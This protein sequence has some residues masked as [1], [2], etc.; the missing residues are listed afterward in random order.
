M[1]LSAPAPAQMLSWLS[2]KDFG[3]KGD[4]QEVADGAMTSGSP[5]L[6]S[7]TANFTASDV[8]KSASV[9][10]AGASNTFLVAPIIG[11][12]SPTTVTL[13][14]N[15]SATVNTRTILW[16]TD[17]TTALQAWI[18]AA[19]SGAK[20]AYLPAGI[21][22]VT[23][24]L[25]APAMNGFTLCGDGQNSVL[26]IRDGSFT[27]S[28]TNNGALTVPGN[29]SN[30]Y[31][32]DFR[33]YGGNKNRDEQ[34]AGVGSNGYAGISLSA[35]AGTLSNVEVFGISASGFSALSFA[36]FLFNGSSYLNIF[37]CRSMQN[38][39][40]FKFVGT[41]TLL[42]FYGCY[43]SSNGAF[44]PAA[45]NTTFFQ[46]INTHITFDTCLFDEAIVGA[47]NPPQH[48]YYSTYACDWIVYRNCT[49]F[50]YSSCT[51][52]TLEGSAVQNVRLE[53]CDVVPYGP[54]TNCSG[55][56]IASG[57]TVEAAN[58]K[59]LANGTGKAVTGAGTFRAGANNRLTGTVDVTAYV[60]QSLDSVLR[61]RVTG[62]ATN[63]TATKANL[64]DLTVTVLS[65]RKYTGRLVLFVKN[66]T[67]AEG[68]QIDFGGGACTFTSAQ[69]GI[70][71]A[72]GATVGTATSTAATTAVTL[73]DMGGTADVVV[74]VEF[75][76]VINA[77]GTLIP[78]VAEVSHTSGTVTVEIGS[79][80]RL[81]DSPN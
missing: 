44:T 3:A 74:T 76:A 30:V 19:G 1:A 34:L 69:F 46:G 67:Q 72:P 4:T 11:Y 31:L 27:W 52:I 50:I 21:Y 47:G 57:C 32:R 81:E 43:T 66:S 15:A 53:D 36:G 62:A 14:A 22:L 45:I 8:G 12:T 54:N 63:A 38:G 55:L 40:Q 10:G 35:Q 79:Y 33:I 68:L 49:L 13:G 58:T 51:G 24:P 42:N 77:G 61:A 48:R 56:S 39:Q 20:A 26:R 80:L 16:G 23:A 65:G 60:P 64:T 70:A 7:A 2:A 6:T 17:D 25:V 41:N 75:E 78:R 71:S 73:T 29:S 9:S 37:G 28:N 59:I 5:T 18:T